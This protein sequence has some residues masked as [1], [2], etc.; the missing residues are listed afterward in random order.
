VKIDILEEKFFVSINTH[1]KVGKVF[2]SVSDS[3]F[4]FT[5]KHDGYERKWEKTGVKK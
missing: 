4:H 1:E 5:R 3:G 2:C